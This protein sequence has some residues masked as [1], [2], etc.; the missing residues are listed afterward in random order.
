MK[1]LLALLPAASLLLLASGASALTTFS[2]ELEGAQEVPPVTTDASGS[3][4]LV[5]NDEQDRLEIAIQTEGLD[6][7]GSQTPEIS[8]DDVVAAH[9]HSAPAGSNGPIVFGFIGPNDDTNGD[10]AIDPAAGTLESAWDADENLDSH[11]EELFNEELYLN[12][13]TQENTGGEIRGQI[14]PEPG[15]TGLLAGGLLLLALRSRGR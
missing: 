8:T 9:I 7:D 1:V 14:V 2:A 3:A 12:I 10:L 4:E 5:L 15:T 6:F 13:H 11:L